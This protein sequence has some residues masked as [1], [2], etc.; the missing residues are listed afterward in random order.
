MTNQESIE[1]V[2]TKLQE[3]LTF[4]TLLAETSSRF[5]NLRGDLQIIKPS[6]ANDTAVFS[7]LRTVI[8]F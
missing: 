5:V 8:K 6:L 1:T 3:R 7:G 2:C 4:E